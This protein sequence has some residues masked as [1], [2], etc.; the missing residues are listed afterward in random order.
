[1]QSNE[2]KQLRRVVCLSSF[3][4]DGRAACRPAVAP[5]VCGRLC[6]RHSTCC[7]H[8]HLREAGDGDAASGGGT[9]D[10][11]SLHPRPLLGVE[12]AHLVADLLGE[13]SRLPLLPVPQHARLPAAVHPQPRQAQ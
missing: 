7:S 13:E 2:L 8:D 4:D 11:A 12:L 9:L 3:D 6:T 5:A 1:M 10:E